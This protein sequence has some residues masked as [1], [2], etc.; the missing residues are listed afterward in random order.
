M[1][2]KA[3]VSSGNFDVM[4]HQAGILAIYAGVSILLT[5]AFF[6]WNGRKPKKEAELVESDQVVTA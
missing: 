2:F 3:V 4:W 5:L 1:G 6:L